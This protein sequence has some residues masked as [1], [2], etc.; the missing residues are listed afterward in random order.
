MK[1]PKPTPLS[2]ILLPVIVLFIVYLFLDY[3]E[4]AQPFEKKQIS[5]TPNGLPTNVERTDVY[6]KSG[7]IRVHGWYYTP[8]GIKNS[9]LIVMASGLG[10]QK[11]VGLDR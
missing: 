11:D 10:G 3:P 5:V 8:V 9:P 2:P 1:H 6:W 7:E 4:S